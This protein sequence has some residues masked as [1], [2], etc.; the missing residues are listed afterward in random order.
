MITI[1]GSLNFVLKQAFGIKGHRITRLVRKGGEW[2][3]SL[4]HDS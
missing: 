4:V 1:K 2:Q 3:L